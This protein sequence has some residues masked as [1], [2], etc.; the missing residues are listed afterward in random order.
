MK[1][2]SHKQPKPVSEGGT[3][4][5]VSPLAASDL[6][7]PWGTLVFVT[8][9]EREFSWA[10]VVAGEN[11]RRVNITQLTGIE[12]DEDVFTKSEWDNTAECISIARYAAACSAIEALK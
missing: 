1:P 9:L 8:K 4:Q 7:V 11:I 6:G 5:I 10:T 2:F 3:A 12:N